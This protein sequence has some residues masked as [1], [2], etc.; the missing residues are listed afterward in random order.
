LEKSNRRQ[1]NGRIIKANTE[2]RR[3]YAATDV[4]FRSVAE[5]R[6]IEIGLQK[7]TGCRP[8]TVI[9]DGRICCPN[10]ELDRCVE[11]HAGRRQ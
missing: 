6:F 4:F 7:M 5:I 3:H 1:L 9:L 11:F 2:D 10:L 8:L